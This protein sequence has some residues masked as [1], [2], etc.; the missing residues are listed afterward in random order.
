LSTNL[1]ENLNFV[2]AKNIFIDVD[3][4]ELN[5]ILTTIGH[6]KV[7]EDDDIDE[8]RFNV[9]DYGGHDDNEIEKK[10]KYNLN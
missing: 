1:D 4:E 9:E 6:I 10:K 3:F 2:I 7:D 8:Q 5:D